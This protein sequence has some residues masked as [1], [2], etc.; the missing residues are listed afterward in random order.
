MESSAPPRVPVVPAVAYAEPA[1]SPR[2][3]LATVFRQEFKYVWRTLRRL[4]VQQRDLEDVTH[5]V[6]L[7]VH[8]QLPLFDV[9]RP[10]RPWIFGIALGSASNYRGLARHRLDLTEDMHEVADRRRSLDEELEGREQTR[11]VHAALQ[12][13]PLEQRAVLLLHE[14]DG[15]PIPEVALS[16]GL[17]LNTAYSRLR[18]ARETFR[19]AFRR[20]AAKGSRP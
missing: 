13:V 14:L 3:D 15:Y 5:E 4:G 9:E 19:G 10:L 18:L 8:A 1:P 12:R 2:L 7:R 16:L 11:L 20:V 17:N 6:F